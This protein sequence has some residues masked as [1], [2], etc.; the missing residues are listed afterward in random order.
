MGD[1]NPQNR[2]LLAMFIKIKNEHD[3]KQQETDQA[4]PV[5]K[6]EV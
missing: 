5:H 2:K 3:Q 4:D 6:E 1:L